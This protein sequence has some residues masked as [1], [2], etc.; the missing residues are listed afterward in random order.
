M[1]ENIPNLHSRKAKGRIY[2]RYLMPD[3]QYESL[4]A[5]RKYAIDAAIA[6][7]ERRAAS[8][9]MRGAEEAEGS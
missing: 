1:A 8:A 3:G 6:L 7:N 2:Y 4:G 5:D 9:E